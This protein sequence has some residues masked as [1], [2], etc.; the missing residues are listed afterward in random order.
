V[1]SLKT[2]LRE[3]KCPL[4]KLFKLIHLKLLEFIATYNALT[5]VKLEVGGVPSARDRPSLQRL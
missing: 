3:K 2:L 1:V 5:V 4:E